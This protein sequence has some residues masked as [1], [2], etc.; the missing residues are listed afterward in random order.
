MKKQHTKSIVTAGFII[1]IILCISGIVMIYS[2][3]IKFSEISDT[4]E[5][6]KELIVTSSL[7]AMLYNVESVGNTLLTEQD[8]KQIAPYDSLM[9]KVHLQMDSLKNISKDSIM[10]IHLDSVSSLLES[11]RENIKRIA[12]L[13]DSIRSNTPKQTTKTTIISQK[14]LDNIQNSLKN[15]A[16]QI[17]DTIIVESKEKNYFKRLGNAVF[18]KKDSS[19]QVS[20]KHEDFV[21]NIVIPTLIDTISEYV[22]EFKWEYD[23]RHKELTHRLMKRQGLMHHM[24]ERLSSQIA[25]IVR[26]V[27]FREY[28]MSLSLMKKKEM[29]LK[30]SSKIVS[31]IGLLAS[32]TAVIFLIMA[33]R[34]LSNSQRY[35]REIETAK[36]YAEDLLEARER[37]IFAI[38]HDIK[39]PISSIIGYLELL[40]NDKLSEKEG[41]YIKNMQHS[42]EHIL[43]LVKNLLDYHAL[44]SDKQD[45]Q[46]MP[47]FPPILMYDIYQS[48]IP[49]AKKAE[50]KF[51]YICNFEEN[52]SFESDPYRIRQICNNIIS[53]ALKFTNTGG[54]V[55]FSVFHIMEKGDDYMEFSIKDNGPGISKESQAIIFEEFK[56][57]EEHKGK[58]EGSGLGLTITR[59]LVSLL[60]GSIHLF[61]EPGQGCEFI[62]RIPLRKTEIKQD[63]PR[64][65]SVPKSLKK[66]SGKKILFIDDDPVQLN[67]YS[68]LLKREGFL[69]KTCKNSL[70]ALSMIEKER[71]DIIFS[72][73]QMPDMNGFELVERIRMGTFKGAKTV[74]VIALSASSNI[75]EQKFKEAGFTG[76]ISKPFTA[77]S[78]LEAIAN[79]FLPENAKPILTEKEDE[80][81]ITNLIKFAQGDSEA[82]KTIIQSFIEENIKN[83]EHIKI[84]VQK[85]DWES[86]S[87][88]A[89]KMLSLMRM[90]SAEQL[91]EILL[92]IESGNKNLEDVDRLIVLTQEQIKAADDFLNKDPDEI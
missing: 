5:E 88:I 47:F 28:E 90:V 64:K 40:S 92:Q 52:A 41:Y 44:E 58:I 61:S 18:N 78:I 31:I 81:G 76:F 26:K 30:R 16:K 8:S 82:A 4:T 45:I 70:E 75:S 49:V 25:S 59:K 6:R 1:L 13:L 89:H 34:S 24:N 79:V 42:S 71:F 74:P 56:R 15:K 37:L 46:N 85:D 84:A 9:D 86:I 23:K 55:I 91:V 67:L 32:L 60:N 48:F 62:V 3:L 10:N 68:E 39:A 35:R 54:K 73:I 57:L 43:D 17:N 33:L 7:M 69:T 14:A 29:T 2:E 80:K 65:A 87:R 51:E 66:L 36:K 12:I 77:N 83:I 63:E 19:L 27:E 50:I 22:N 20:K 53:N 72:D 11:K 38:T 21:E